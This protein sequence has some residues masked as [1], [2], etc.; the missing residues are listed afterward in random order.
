MEIQK[1]IDDLIISPKTLLGVGPM[2]KNCVDVVIDICNSYSVPI[3][4][5]GSRRQ[6]EASS[7]GGGYVNSWSTETLSEYIS[8]KDKSGLVLL[9]RDHGGPWQNYNEVSEDMNLKDAIESSKNSFETDILNG[10][11]FIHIDPSVD[12]HQEISNEDILDRVF[13]LYSFCFDVA[14]ENN[15]K[16]YIEVGT[17]EQKEGLNQY[18]EVEYNIQSITRFCNENKYDSP[19]FYVVQ[20]GSKVKEAENTG[21]FQDLDLEN[22]EKDSSI[23]EIKKITDLCLTHNILPKAHNSDYLSFEASSI[24][25]KINLKGGN[26]APEFGVLESKV[27]IDLLQK[28]KLDSELDEFV[29]LSIN[30]GKWVKWMKEE[31]SASDLDKAIISGHYIFS[32][33]EFKDLKNKIESVLSVNKLDLDTEIKNVLKDSIVNYLRAY[34]WG[35]N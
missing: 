1:I 32:L 31:S 24:Y 14:A 10:F 7:S 9:S 18:Q 5:I 22:Y 19:I 16:I 27:I 8:K 6:I 34:G 29:G 23:K 30:S 12:I 28:F 33:P 15:K 13:E 20:N 21:I 17:E 2:S 26:I 3:Q 35:I 25:P 4:L 11:Q